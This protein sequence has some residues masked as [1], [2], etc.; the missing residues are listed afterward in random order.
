MISKIFR[1]EFPISFSVFSVQHNSTSGVEMFDNFIYYF[2]SSSCQ[3]VMKNDRNETK[4][5]DLLHVFFHVRQAGNKKITNFYR[6]K[7]HCVES[8]T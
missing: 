6:C 5:K 3:I 4:K 1:G 2:Y 7:R 8:G